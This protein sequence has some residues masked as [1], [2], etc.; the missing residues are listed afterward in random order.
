M[1]NT[2]TSDVMFMSDWWEMV[3]SNKID[4]DVRYRILVYAVN[5]F[6]QKRVREEIGV[7]RATIW[8]L[9]GRRSPVK[10]EYV[11]SVLKLL[12]L[13][14]FERIVEARRK[15]RALGIVRDD[16]S[17]DYSLALEMLAVARNDEYLKNA[18]LRFVVQ[19][20]S[21]DL[22]RMLGLSFTGL[23]FHWTDDL[24]ISL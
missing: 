12:S 1:E 6:G 16:G 19:E 7:S 13:E 22:K 17:I 20:F 11:K 24:S 4:E 5:K 15:L 18:I 14:E 21:E 10:P 2:E 9:I 3:D 8:R 23:K